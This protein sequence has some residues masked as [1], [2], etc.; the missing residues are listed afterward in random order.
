MVAS[1]SRQR[2]SEN[3]GCGLGEIGNDDPALGMVDRGNSSK[4]SWGTFYVPF[5]IEAAE[6]N[7]R[8][9]H[10]GMETD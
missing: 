5:N 10:P 1:T 8:R 9:I 4:Q 3:G 6:N 7:A 2:L